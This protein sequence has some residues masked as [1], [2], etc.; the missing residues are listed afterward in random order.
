M[1]IVSLLPSATEIVCFLGLEDQLLGIT[2][3][4][5]YPE[6]IR[7]R[8]KLTSSI[9]DHSHST[10]SQIDRHIKESLHQGSSIYFLDR[11]LLDR[12][13]PDLVITQELCDVCAVSYKEVERAVKELYGERR[14]ISLD[15]GNIQ[16]VLASI[17]TVAGTVGIEESAR[18]LVSGLQERIDRV[19]SL[20]KN[21][22]H[23][24]RVYCM[25]WYDP[26]YSAGHW[27]P[28]MVEMAGGIE[29]LGEAELPSRAVSWEEI[30]IASPEMIILMPCG[31]DLAET[32]EQ[33]KK[34]SLPA[35][36]AGLPAVKSGNIYAV[37]GSA[38][39]NRPGPRLVDGL[40]I[41]AQLLHPELNICKI[42]EDQAAK[43]SL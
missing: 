7:N 20:T 34:A 16:E 21:V 19:A 36:W 41:L 30:S 18:S 23:R 12:L 1:R 15:P 33:A 24:P 3:E 39:Y 22:S 43:I 35:S 10:P 6:S 42:K 38:Y 13:D 25:E 37:N 31:Y 4:C 9:I 28:G 27:V 11:E 40:E 14:V 8:P 17:M 2:H 29:V 5:D 26:P 32:L